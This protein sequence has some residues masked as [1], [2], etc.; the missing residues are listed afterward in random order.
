[1]DKI[2]I[3][4]DCDPG[5]D[6]AIAIILALASKKLD[7]KAITAVNGNQTLN[8]T[9][10]NVLKIVEF[11]GEDIPVGKGAPKPLFKECNP[12]PSCHG[13]SGMD[14]PVLPE[15]TIKESDLSA[16]DLIAKIVCESEKKIT[17]V[18]TGPLTN[19]AVF[20]LAYPELLGKIERISL[21]GG[22]LFTGNRSAAAEFNLWQ[23]PEAAAIVFN[24]GIPIVMHGLDVT[25]KALLY[26]EDVAKLREHGGK[27]SIFVAELFDFFFKFYQ[28]QDFDGAPIHDACA[29]AWLIAPE[30]FTCQKF[31]VQ[32]DITG[33]YTAGAT[34]VDT[35]PRSDLDK[36]TIVSLDID[37]EKFVSMLID[38]CKSY[39]L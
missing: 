28:H 31:N 26:P 20:I 36:N 32:V 35:R 18:P 15:P 7:V 27:V 6:D 38:A 24:S 10:K 8:K 5:H 23:D 13:E 33:D 1:M 17:L 14:G 4:L 3:I 29:V 2:P 9:L 39:K 30:I 37:R 19:I 25:H 21:M 22:S 16:V 34:V 12:A 11:L